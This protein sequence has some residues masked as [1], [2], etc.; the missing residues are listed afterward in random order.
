MRRSRVGRSKG[1]QGCRPGGRRNNDTEIFL[2]VLKKKNKVDLAAEVLYEGERL[3][4]LV[5]HQANR[6]LV[7][8]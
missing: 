7:H 6:R 1:C 5:P 3:P 2:L 4:P 8:H